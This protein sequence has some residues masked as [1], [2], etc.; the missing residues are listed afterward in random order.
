VQFDEHGYREI[1]ELGR[2]LN[3]A[4]RELSKVDDLCRE[5]IANISHDL[6]TPLTMIQGYGEVMRDIP[7]ENTPENVQIVIDEANRLTTLVNDVLDIAS[8]Q[9]GQQKFVSAPFN[10]TEA[11]RQT[12]VRYNKL[13]ER[14]G[15][16]MDFYSDGEIWVD[17]DEGRII[18][19]LCNLINN[20]MTYTGPDKVV[21]LRQIT[22]GEVVRIEVTDTGEGIP[23]EKMEFIWERY[24]RGDKVHRRSAAGSGLGLSIVRHIIDMA[25]GRCG[26][27]SVLGQGSTFW[28]ELRILFQPKDAEN[29]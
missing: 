25:G 14:N 8:F 5:L 16:H 29:L 3:Y 7:G 19:V 2:T 6:R 28:F 18:Q 24:Y 11:V 13:V 1:R 9:N 23:R 4:T 27:R 22:E 15:Y 17:S 26:V 21:R 12:L 10:L 20:A